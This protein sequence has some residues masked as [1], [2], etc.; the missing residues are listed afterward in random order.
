LLLVI[1]EIN[2]GGEFLLVGVATILKP[3]AL[4]YNPPLFVAR[5]PCLDSNVPP[6]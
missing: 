6:F 5:A 2:A 4:D 1:G 3:V